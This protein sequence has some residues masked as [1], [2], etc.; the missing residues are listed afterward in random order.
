MTWNTAFKDLLKKHQSG[1]GYAPAF[2]LQ[3]GSCMIVGNHV[4][5]WEKDKGLKALEISSHPSSSSIAPS[6]GEWDDANPRYKRTSTDLGYEYLYT[7]GL[8]GDI[9]MGAQAIHPR[10][11]VYTPATLRVGV[12]QFAASCAAQMTTG[13]LACMQIN[14]DGFGKSATKGA[15]WNNIFFGSFKGMSFNG[16]SYVLTFDDAINN[17][18]W[19]STA[20]SVY[21]GWNLEQFPNWFAGCGTTSKTKSYS[22][23]TSFSSTSGTDWKTQQFW[24]TRQADRS[25]FQFNYKKISADFIGAAYRPQYSHGSITTTANQMWAKVAS[26]T[27]GEYINYHGA[28]ELDGRL[29]LNDCRSMSTTAPPGGWIGYMPGFYEHAAADSTEGPGAAD[30]NITAYCVVSGTPVT[31]FVNTVYIQGY[32]PFMVPGIFAYEMGAEY[33]TDILNWT[34]IDTAQRDFVTQFADHTGVRGYENKMSPVKANMTEKTNGLSTMMKMCG[35]WGC[36]MRFK[37]GGYG[38]ATYPSYVLGSGY[39][40]YNW[41]KFTERSARNEIIIGNDIE[42]ASMQHISPQTRGSYRRLRYITKAV[43]REDDSTTEND[44]EIVNGDPDTVRDA[45]MHWELVVDTTNCAEG[46]LDG[47]ATRYATYIQGCHLNTYTRSHVS[48]D[49][50]L[51]GLKHAHLAPGDWVDVTIETAQ[52]GFQATDWGPKD[53]LAHAHTSA[54][55]TI[56]TYFESDGDAKSTRVRPPWMVTSAHVDW[57]R[58]T[59]SLGLTRINDADGSAT[60]TFWSSWLDEPEKRGE[61]LDMGM[62]TFKKSGK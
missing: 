32:H 20:R 49:I 38:M 21:A 31:E 9:T 55:S 39:D 4:G 58:C 40:T 11:F 24:A 29:F 62:P 57:M 48:C 51:R 7:V 43:D 47:T 2:R 59:V 3:I 54:F 13:T 26:T 56:E 1:E 33:R 50:R 14:I 16:S 27:R 10:T 18:K 22:T 52:P 15:G 25:L 8:T 45:P 5:G 30:K 23:I 53:T 6:D 60:A 19:N 36:N 12:S 41:D 28:G 37:E 46:Y 44:I 34:D 61:S 35:K 17:A 42:G